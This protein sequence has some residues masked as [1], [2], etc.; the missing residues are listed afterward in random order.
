M[1]NEDTTGAANAVPMMTFLTK[2]R[3]LAS[4]FSRTFSFAS[5]SDIPLFSPFGPVN[6][7]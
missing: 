7:H 6:R 1:E 3:R 5:T 2:P 4:T